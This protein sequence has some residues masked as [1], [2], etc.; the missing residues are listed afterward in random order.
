[1]AVENLKPESAEI[2]PVDALA[3]GQHI[4]ANIIA[5]AY[6]RTR[7]EG[8]AEFQ[9]DCKMKDKEVKNHESISG[10]GRNK[11]HGRSLH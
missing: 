9:P 5:R 4:L 6:L 2:E 11:S 1:M 7:K 3:E 8:Q 10:A